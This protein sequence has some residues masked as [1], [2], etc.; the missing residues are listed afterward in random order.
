MFTMLAAIGVF[1]AWF[2]AIDYTRLSHRTPREDLIDSYVQALG[3]GQ[4]NLIGQSLGHGPRILD[5]SYFNGRVYIYYGIGPFFLVL[6]PW[7]KMTGSYLTPEV[8]VQAALLAGYAAYGFALWLLFGRDRSRAADWLLPAA[9]LAVVVSS[10]TW[11]LMDLA[12]IHQLESAFAYAFTGLTVA[13]LTIAFRGGRY[14]GIALGGAAMFIGLIMACRPNCFLAAGILA[15]AAGYLCWKTAP[16]N[17]RWRRTAGLV[18]GPLL[19]IGSGLGAWNYVRFGNILEF[20]MKYGTG[21]AD[22]PAIAA[23]SPGNLIYN[24][25]RY[26]VGGIRWEDYF[27][28][29][30]GMKEGPFPRPLATHESL[31]Q[32]YGCLLLFPVLIFAGFALWKRRGPTGVLLVAA[33]ANLFVLAGLGFGTYRYPADYLGPLSFVAGVGVCCVGEMTHRVTRRLALGA[34]AILLSWSS[35]LGL[36]Q[37]I[38]ISST[39]AQ[40]D[41]KR[42]KAFATLAAPFN[43]A[44]YQWERITGTDPRAFRLHLSLPNSRYGKTEPLLVSGEVGL[45]DFIYFYYTEP[46]KIQIGFES[47]GHGGPVSPP[48]AIDYAQPHVVDISLGSL[49]PPDDHP[50]LKSLDP[51]DRSNARRFIRVTLDGEVVLEDLVHLHP[52]RSRIFLGRSPDDAA[53]GAAFTGTIASVDRP[54]L[55]DLGVGPK[56]DST[57]FGPLT[58]AL[59][60][61]LTDV[62]STLPVVSI[63]NRPGGGM[64]VLECLSPTSVR[65]QWHRYGGPVISSEPVPWSYGSVHTLVFH[66]GSLLP[67]VLSSLWDPAKPRVAREEAKRIMRCVLDGQEVWHSE[68]IVPDASPRMVKVGMNTFRLS[69]VAASLDER[70]VRSGRVAW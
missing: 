31:V 70:L 62:G 45:Q 40:F 18:G 65:F 30:D 35:A 46:G 50:L 17:R 20:G 23:F 41:L 55:R 66:V 68:E 67:P 34:L 60:L 29:I 33:G 58:L 64:L 26:L 4:P 22:N 42:P 1:L 3:A 32:V 57:L 5:A 24:L 19:L 47:M 54:R 12:N 16:P 15:V 25:H 10:G 69:G 56:W 8:C 59:D 21:A 11:P 7:Y 52:T 37:T 53:F 43:R 36:C 38:S 44:I 14:A 28:F 13:L 49:L 61:K 2:M 48:L 39:T 63:G 9:F 51:G 6:L 27:P